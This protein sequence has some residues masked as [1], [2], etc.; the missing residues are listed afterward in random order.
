MLGGVGRW[1]GGNKE[2][3][4]HSL[5]P[6]SSSH[7]RAFVFSLTNESYQPPWVVCGSGREKDTRVIGGV[8]NTR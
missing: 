2:S 8:P 4:N 3:S 6:L 7:P 1:K 5:D